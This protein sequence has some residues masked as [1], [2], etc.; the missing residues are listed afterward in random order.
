MNFN[1]AFPPAPW[2]YAL[3]AAAATLL[4]IGLAD[5]VVNHGAQTMND[6]IYQLVATLIS[7]GWTLAMRVVS[8][9][10]EWY[11][12]LALALLLMLIPAT[13]W[14]FGLVAT[15]TVLLAGG[16]D[17]LL[18]FALAQ[19]RPP[20]SQ[21]L[22]SEIGYGFPSGHATTAM[23]AAGLVCWIGWSCTSKPL[24]R[25]IICILSAFWF[26]TVGFSR[27]Y[28]GVHYTSDVF[29]GWLLGMAVFSLV[30]LAWSLQ[31]QKNTRPQP[32]Q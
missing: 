6:Q 29:G 31:R 4:F 27:V 24:W 3:S 23:V 17:Q 5:L 7:P 13:R 20:I 19:P 12:A 22:V 9:L 11:V 28:L 25:A 14:R 2:R 26:L 18:K 32:S 1:T 21:W 30:L 10:G 15:S 16:L 8:W